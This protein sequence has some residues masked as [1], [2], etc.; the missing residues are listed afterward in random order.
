MTKYFIPHKTK[1]FIDPEH[2]W[3]NNKVKTVTQDLSN[4][5]EK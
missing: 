5:F 2:F 4:L 3:I 1:I